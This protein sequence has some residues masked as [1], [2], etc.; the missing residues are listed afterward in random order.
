VLAIEKAANEPMTKKCL[1]GEEGEGA[2]RMTK[3]AELLSMMKLDS[4][5]QRKRPMRK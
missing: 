4:S 2:L 3:E 5:E 1:E